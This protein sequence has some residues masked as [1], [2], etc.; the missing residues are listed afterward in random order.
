MFDYIMLMLE[1]IM[2][3]KNILMSDTFHDFCYSVQI[4]H[5]IQCNKQT[6]KQTQTHTFPLHHPLSNNS[7][8]SAD[9]WY[10][11]RLSFLCRHLSQFTQQK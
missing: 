10:I 1:I 2:T 5:F 9:V 7:V 6:N 3:I 8:H 11:S 4:C